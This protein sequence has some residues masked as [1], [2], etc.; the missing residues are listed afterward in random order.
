MFTYSPSDILITVNGFPITGLAEDDFCNVEKRTN[1]AE[2]TIGVDGEGALSRS[3]DESGDITISCAAHSA[4]NDIMM[5]AYAAFKAIGAVSAIFVKDLNGR[6]L[7]VAERAFPEKL[8][9]KKYGKKAGDMVWK[10]TTD[11]LVSNI[12]GNNLAPTVPVE[13]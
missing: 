9:P 12:G 1:D 5:A 10:W 11:K 13:T 2:L 3:K 7:H 8:P 4:A 6:S